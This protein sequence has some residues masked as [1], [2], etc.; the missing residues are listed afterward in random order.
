M[1]T[2]VTFAHNGMNI[3]NPFASECSRFEVEPEHYGFVKQDCGHTFKGYLWEKVTDTGWK[4]R[5][6]EIPEGELKS[7]TITGYRPDGTM[8]HTNNIQ[9]AIDAYEAGEM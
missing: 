6:M 2:F 5:L 4:I 9:E 7:R 3:F 8:W 1:K